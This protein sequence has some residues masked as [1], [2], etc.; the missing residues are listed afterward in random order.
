MKFIY[1]VRIDN[2]DAVTCPTITDCKRFIKDFQ[3]HNNTIHEFSIYNEE[4]G[5][6]IEIKIKENNT[7][8]KQEL[9]EKAIK[10]MDNYTRAVEMDLDNFANY[11]N[12]QMKTLCNEI[13]RRGLEQEFDDFAL[14][15]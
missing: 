3:R 10:A 13:R 5:T 8:K 7:M 14:V 9:F 6:I 4:T 12:S 2:D 1:T 15:F 11:Y